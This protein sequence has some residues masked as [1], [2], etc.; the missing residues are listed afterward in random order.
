M[1]KKVLIVA[2]YWPPAGG[3]GVQRWLMFV[4]Y[5][6][7]F[8]IEPIVYTPKNARHPQK[9]F[10]FTNEIPEG[11]TVI[12]QPIFEPQTLFSSIFKD[13]IKRLSKGV[14]NSKNQGFIEKIL[15]WVRGNLF[16]PDSR[17][18]WV[19]PSIRFL[20]KYLTLNPVDAVITTGP[21]HSLH[22][23]GLGLKKTI[24]I[25]W[26]ADFRDPWTTI[27]Y[28]SK[29]KLT[30]ASAALHKKMEREVLNWAD[31]VLVTSF[32]TQKEFGAITP[33]PV[34]VITNGYDSIETPDLPLHQKFSISHI[35]SLL[36]GRNPEVLWK[37]L[38]E[39]IITEKGFADDFVLN[40]AGV[41]SET[42]LQSIGQHIPK[43]N[44]TVLGYVSHQDTLLLQ[45]ISQVLLLIEIN[46]EETKCIIPGKLFEYMAA[47]R[48]ILAIGPQEWDAAKIIEK[49]N[50]GQVFLYSDEE[51][52]KNHLLTL[53]RQFNLGIL[54]VE[55][56]GIEK[57][58]RKALTGELADILNAL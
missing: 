34:M 7:D 43:E 5:L 8:G 58:S 36:S 40:L 28:H 47:K 12:Q 24:G 45:K 22:L 9:D 31:K 16:I 1:G 6:R 53:Y 14:I 55:P 54:Q 25:K 27:G 52:L 15:M 48:P 38:G 32:T 35:G 18:F 23:I 2:Y 46:S 33:K 37:V 26:V 39:L 42:V 20:K 19:K 13:K 51:N 11:I 4:K 10:S 29:L 30:K 41:I 49:T 44:L 3:P 56:K 50:T 21:P 17:K 57:Y